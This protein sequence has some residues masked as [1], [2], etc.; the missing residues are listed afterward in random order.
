MNIMYAAKGLQFQSSCKINSDT[1]YR[2]N[3]LIEDQS[4]A[5]ILYDPAHPSRFLYV[6]AMLNVS[7]EIEA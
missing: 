7:P 6:D 1:A 3:K 2:A 5:R 4:P